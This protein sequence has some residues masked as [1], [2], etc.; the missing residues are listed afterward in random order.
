MKRTLNDREPRMAFSHACASHWWLTAATVA[1]PKRPQTSNNYTDH[2][3]VVSSLAVQHC[4]GPLVAYSLL[5]V[6]PVT[7]R[8]SY[9]ADPML[10][11]LRR[12]CHVR[13]AS[14][15]LA[16]PLPFTQLVLSFVGTPSCLRIDTWTDMA[17]PQK[18]QAC[19]R[20]GRPFGD[21]ACNSMRGLATN[22]PCDKPIEDYSTL[23]RGPRQGFVTEGPRQRHVTE[24]GGGT[25]TNPYFESQP[26]V[27]V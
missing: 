12:G 1:T 25:S 23:H 5:P 27:Y 2:V 17:A 7:W 21:K 4:S 3:V 15:M 13:S 14:L 16:K 20:P 6:G 11:V 24:G 19:N 8:L 26:C 9:P 18:H 10:E 22:P